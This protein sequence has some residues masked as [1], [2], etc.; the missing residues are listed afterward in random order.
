[1]QHKFNDHVGLVVCLVV[2]L[3]VL[4]HD[5]QV[6]AGRGVGRPHRQGVAVVGFRGLQIASFVQDATEVDVGIRV[7]RRHRQDLA[8]AALRMGG[9]GL[10][11][12]AAE[13]EPTVVLGD[14]QRLARAVANL[15]DNACQWSPPDGTVEVRAANGEVRVRDHGPGLREEDLPL[16]FERFYRASAA[17]GK[18]GAGLGLAIVRQVAEAHGGTI[19][20]EDAPGGGT[21]MR[22]RLGAR[23][24]AA[25]PAIADPVRA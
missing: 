3:L 8:V 22:M 6:E 12:F 10:V 9:V 14:P 23:P 18:P 21:V 20:A 13:L 11:H 25:A 7:V 17:R 19:V 5:P 1:M 16:V 24:V 15:L 2:A 4:E